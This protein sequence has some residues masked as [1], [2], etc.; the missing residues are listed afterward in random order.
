VRLRRYESVRDPPVSSINT[1][2]AEFWRAMADALVMRQS[3]SFSPGVRWVSLSD[4]RTL[5]VALSD[6]LLRF[7]VRCSILERAKAVGS[8]RLGLIVGRPTNSEPRLCNSQLRRLRVSA[9]T[10]G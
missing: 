5:A 1:H 10:D 4:P 2:A 7:E 9:S 6:L 8:S 3:H